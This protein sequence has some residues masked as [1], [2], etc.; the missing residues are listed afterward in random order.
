MP[1]AEGVLS[2]IVSVSAEEDKTDEVIV[3]VIS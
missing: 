1:L 3:I 2:T